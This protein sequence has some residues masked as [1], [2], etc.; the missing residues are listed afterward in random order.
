MEELKTYAREIGVESMTLV[1]LIDSHRHLRNQALKSND[2]LRH[3]INECRE[4][5]AASTRASIQHGEYI[6]VEKLRTMNLG[7]IAKLIYEE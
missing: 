1:S 6:S 3:E 2:E 4:R 5:V 7:E